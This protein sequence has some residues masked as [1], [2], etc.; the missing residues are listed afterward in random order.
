[1]SVV[2]R[3]S[4]VLFF[5]GSVVQAGE[6]SLAEKANDIL[7]RHCHQCHGLG[8]SSKGGLSAILDRELL[9]SRSL[10]VPGRP[11]DSE[12]Y[13][14]VKA[15]EMPPPNKKPRPDADGVNVLRDWI[16]AGAP[17]L[18]GAPRTFIT[19]T[20]I[21]RLIRDDVQTYPPKQRRFLRYVSF[22]HLHNAGRP[23]T[24]MQLTAPGL[25][26]LVNT[27]SWHARITQPTPIDPARTLFRLDL[28]DYR[29]TARTWERIVAVY[30]Y[31]LPVDAGERGIGEAVGA[32]VF[33]IRGD[34]LLATASRGKL[35]YELLEM[36]A[37][38]RALERILQ[39]DVAR[40]LQDETTLRAGFNGSGVSRNN[41]VIER[42]DALHGAYWRS[43]DFADNSGRQNI[44]E[45]PVG[46][47]AGQHSFRPAGGEIIFN[48]PNG[49]QGY[50]LVNNTGQ[51]VEKAP[52]EIVSDPLR[53]DKQVEAG[54]SC[55][56]CHGRGLIPKDDQVRAHVEKN[57]AAFPADVVDAVRSLYPL[58]KRLRVL[59]DA[60]TKRYLTALE[61]TG[62]P[63]EGPEPVS[64]LTLR[65]EGVVGLAEVAAEFGL[66]SEEF[67]RKLSASPSLLRLF[68]AL[69]ARA[70]TVQRPLIEEQF[71]RLVSL[72]AR[73]GTLETTV[74]SRKV[75]VE[76]AFEGHTDAVRS[77][78]LSPDGKLALSGGQDQTLRL[79]DIATGRLL[80]TFEGHDAAIN[81]VAFSPDGTR[82]LSASD[83]RTVRL[84]ETSTGKELS[85]LKGHLDRVRAVV[86][87]PNGK[88]A[89]SAGQDRTLRWWD[90]DK[91]T[92]IRSFSGHTG[93]VLCV[94]ISPDGKRALSGGI[95]GTLRLWDVATGEEKENRD[96][97]R[98]GVLCV[99][100][101]PDGKYVASG[102]EDRTVR[103]WEVDGL[104][105]MRSMTGHVNALLTVRFTE[106]GKQVLS[107]SSQTNREDRFLRAWDVNGKEIAGR[108]GNASVW[109]AAF[110]SDGRHALTGGTDRRL[111]RWSLAP[112]G[113]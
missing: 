32:D 23:A 27:L 17:A 57:A 102:G 47:V 70:G 19:P 8:G 74:T 16:A 113:R 66:R 42:H 30:P 48:L 108:E 72:A 34:W 61:A 56:T 38:D 43:H 10:I 95:D 46:P 85:R 94:A 45:N 50:M 4:A 68:G 80:R 58:P 91:G 63:A 39:V 79:W 18:P 36:P 64:T 110:T 40:D 78:A 111:Q 67:T 76:S 44:F 53:P 103:M 90:L 99:A 65:Y 69:Q 77:L 33:V 88:R 107:A 12:L 6:P 1:M 55:M 35:Y 51:R 49:M 54:L 21:A 81:S 9:V 101:S 73:P 97:H 83:D 75:D 52:V 20:D 37:S 41:R 89:M 62:I 105:P 109:C 14:K 3:L 93:P 84:W 98:R 5:L 24:E 112:S 25:S 92:E 7:T 86:F 96:A 15:G 71:P 59:L 87:A 100:F 13:R 106:D 104:S 22:T 2:S 28:R 11:A 60:D 26:K 29:W 82:I 31:R